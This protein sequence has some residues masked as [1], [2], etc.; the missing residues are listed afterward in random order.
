MLPLRWGE[1]IILNQSQGGKH[2]ASRFWFKD[3]EFPGGKDL[4]RRCQN[5]NIKTSNSGCVTY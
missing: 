1:S 2:K 5:L 4:E 3:Y